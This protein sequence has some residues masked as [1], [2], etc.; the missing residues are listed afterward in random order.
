MTMPDILSQ[1]PDG[2][3]VPELSHLITEDD[4]PVDNRF[5]ERQQKLLSAVLFESWDEGKPFEALVDVGLPRLLLQER[6]E[7]PT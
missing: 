3:P 5:S 6:A 4:R 7:P 2:P 1:D